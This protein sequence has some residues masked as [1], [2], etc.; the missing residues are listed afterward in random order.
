MA[1]FPYWAAIR[2]VRDG[3][4]GR[5]GLNQYREGGGK[6]RDSTWYKLVGHAQEAM[7]KRQKE[8]TAPLDR[9]PTAEYLQHW[10]TKKKTG[11]AQQVEILARDRDTNELIT[12]PYTRFGSTLVSRQSVI[13]DALSTITPEGTDGDRQQILGA[14]YVGTYVATPG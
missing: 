5:Q 8:V 10:P 9:R 13:D 2:S 11:I 7:S 3:L 12:I 14:S 1:E 6:I 4:S